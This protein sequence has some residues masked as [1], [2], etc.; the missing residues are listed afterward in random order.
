MFYKKSFIFV[1]L[2]IICLLFG[3]VTANAQ[4]ATTQEG[5]LYTLGKDDVLEIIVQNQPEF[6][7]PFVVGPDGKVQYSYAGDIQAEGLTKEELKAEIEKV[8]ERF[9]KVPLVS[10]AIAEYRSKNVYILGEV[11]RPGKYPM[12]GD[13]ISLYDAIVQAGLPTREAALRR[14]YVVKSDTE[15]PEYKKIDLYKIL[16][17]GITKDN[18]NLVSNDI[19]VVP[20][21][22]PSEINRALSN[23]LSPFSRARAADLMMNYDWGS[24]DNG[25]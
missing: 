17:K 3:L 6:S 13:T 24:G 14:I 8:L 15:K 22:V 7:G 19:V 2:A 9:V 20:S 1:S 25:L 11:H 12:K 4:E 16:Y 21:T 5:V 10:I 23:L 18:V